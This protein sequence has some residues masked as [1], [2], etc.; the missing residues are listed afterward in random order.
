MIS[1]SLAVVGALTCTG[2]ALCGH[3]AMAAAPAQ[4]YGKSVVVFW[5]ED[6]M[7]RHGDEGPFTQAIL[8]V[9]ESIYISG[10]GRFFAKTQWPGGDTRERFGTS[11]VGK[12]II[13]FTGRSLIH[14]TPSVMG[15][16]HLQ[17]DFDP[18]FSSCT[19]SIIVGRVPGSELFIGRNNAT[20]QLNMI[21]SVS[22][23][24]INCSIKPGNVFSE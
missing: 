9:R 24:G 13:K 17:I 16:R 23:S 21:K 6:R 10:A 4:L 22:I 14:D 3:T 19:A 5:S 8:H 11:L 12:G 1:K 7:Q 15:A 2:V 20:G 18:N